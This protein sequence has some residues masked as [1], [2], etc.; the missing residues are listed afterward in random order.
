MANSGAILTSVRLTDVSSTYNSS[1][2][3]KG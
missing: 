1:E 2:S 3:K